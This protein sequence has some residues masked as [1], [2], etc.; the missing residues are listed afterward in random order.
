VRY[1]RALHSLLGAVLWVLCGLPAAGREPVTVRFQYWGGLDEIPSIERIVRDFN[2]THPHIRVVAQRAPGGGSYTQKL[3][4]QV[5][6][7]VAPDVVFVEVDGIVPLM[8]KDVLLPLDPY[9]ARTPD[10]KLSDYYPEVVQRFRRNGKLYILPRD[11]APVCVVYYNKKM[12]DEAGIPYPLDDWSWDTDPDR[13]H[14][15][16]FDPDK[17]F[18]S[19]CHRLVQTHSGGKTQRWAFSGG[20]TNFVFSAGGRLVDDEDNPTKLLFDD[21]RVINAAQLVADMQNRWRIAPRRI[22]VEGENTNTME[23]FIQGRLAMYVNGIWDSPILREIQDFDWDVAQFPRGPTGL[24]GWP[25]GGSGY[26]ITRDCGHPE[27]AWEFVRYIGGV[28]GQTILARNGRAQPALAT[29]ARSPVWMDRGK[30]LHKGEVVNDA[31][32]L[33]YTSRCV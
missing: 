23:L 13:V 20:W 25:T 7:G 14:R 28:P 31:P 10:T 18:L 21:P 2:A 26:G 11:T 30:P 12:F 4:V 24:R 3:L 15:P 27:A 8:D 33:L 29:L 19:I 32:C 9:L 17:D 16:G 5:A 22:D 6:G 1:L